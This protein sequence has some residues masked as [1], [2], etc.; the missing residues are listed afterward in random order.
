MHF[1]LSLSL[2]LLF[3]KNDGKKKVERINVKE[4]GR[5]DTRLNGGANNAANKG[6]AGGVAGAASVSAA[7][8]HNTGLFDRFRKFLECD[9]KKLFLT[10]YAIVSSY[11]TQNTQKVYVILSAIGVF[12]IFLIFLIYVT[13]GGRSSSEADNRQEKI[14][15]RGNAALLVLRLFCCIFNFESNL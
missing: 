14:L 9:K 7:S 4:R 3:A 15:I 10:Y 1:F 11:I 13:S 8:N 5:V 6:A 2:C 12:L